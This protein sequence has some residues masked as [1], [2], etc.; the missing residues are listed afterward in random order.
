MRWWPVRNG[1]A[2]VW[3]SMS[4]MYQTPPRLMHQPT[5][6]SP[7][8]ATKAW[9]PASNRLSAIE[10][11]ACLGAMNKMIFVVGAVGIEPTTSRV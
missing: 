5:C 8:V 4:S 3:Q 11:N 2:R 1:P 10:S 9:R 6:T 7:A